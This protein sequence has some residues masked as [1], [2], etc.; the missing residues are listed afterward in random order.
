[1]ARSYNSIIGISR[2]AGLNEPVVLASRTRRAGTTPTRRPQN[3][4]RHIAETA[5]HRRREGLD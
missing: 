2:N 5:H 3:R 4:L 1:M